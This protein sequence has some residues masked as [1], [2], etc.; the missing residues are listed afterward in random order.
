MSRKTA[1]VAHPSPAVLQ[2]VQAALQGLDVA[3][4]HAPDG[5][6]PGQPGPLDIVFVGLR[7][8][9]GASGYELA[10]QLR[11]AH[12]AALVLLVAGAMEVVD[13]ARVDASGADGVLYPPI[14]AK[15]IRARLEATLGPIA[16]GPVGSGPAGG[17]GPGPAA[18]G[19]ALAPGTSR[20]GSSLAPESALSP[21]PVPPPMPSDE[22]LA[23]FLPREFRPTEPVTVDPALVGPALERAILEVLP[24]VVEAVLRNALVTS[25]TFRDQVRAA[26]DR[27]VAEQLPEALRAAEPH[28][29]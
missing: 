6:R 27:A 20:A 12:P 16:P 21:S 7:L 29:K 18:A 28:R 14:T 25:P 23:T 1:L 26:V 17:H 22:R 3:V 13:R 9:G 10:R 5:R 2:S 11:E 24:E 8:H 15:V 19:A 4:V